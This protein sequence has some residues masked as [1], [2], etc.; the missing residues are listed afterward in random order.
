[1]LEQDTPSNGEIREETEPDNHLAV[2]A[3]AA[4]LLS[5]DGPHSARQ[6]ANTATSQAQAFQ[7]TDALKRQKR[8]RNYKIA[9]A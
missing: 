7:A 1:M 5:P 8:A 2:S 6:G 3:L 4:G 9:Y